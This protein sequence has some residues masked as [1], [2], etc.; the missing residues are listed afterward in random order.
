MNPGTNRTTVS[1]AFNALRSGDC[2][3]SVRGT[4]HGNAAPAVIEPAR[5]SNERLLMRSLTTASLGRWPWHFEYEFHVTL[6][7]AMT[8]PGRDH[9]HLDAEEADVRRHFQ[10]GGGAMGAFDHGALC[11]CHIQPNSRN[12]LT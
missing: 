6:P 9:A 7:G 8:A 12:S 3:R 2:A 4:L 5:A 11:S 10:R 1:A